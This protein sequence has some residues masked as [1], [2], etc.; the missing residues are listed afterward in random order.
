MQNWRYFRDVLCIAHEDRHLSDLRKKTNRWFESLVWLLPEF[1]FWAPEHPQRTNRLWVSISHFSLGPE[2]S[3][4]KT[5]VLP[6]LYVPLL[7]CLVA[8]GPLL[9][10]P[11]CSNEGR[12]W[13]W[14]KR[15]LWNEWDS[16]AYDRKDPLIFCN[17]FLTSDKV[18]QSCSYRKV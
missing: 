15:R 17:F 7:L 12:N 11:R 9:P 4:S 13:S 6:V 2:K 16:V 10:E 8:T 1:P 5:P 14:G 3:E 18:A